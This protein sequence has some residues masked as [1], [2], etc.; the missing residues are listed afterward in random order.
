V[1]DL[2]DFAPMLLMILHFNTSA[3]SRKVER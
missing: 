2:R 1:V 3:D